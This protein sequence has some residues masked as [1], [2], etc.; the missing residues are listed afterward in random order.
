[1]ICRTGDRDFERDSARR[2]RGRGRGGTAS[3]RRVRWDDTA[4]TRRVTSPSSS[5]DAAASTVVVVAAAVGLVAASRF[6]SALRADS[7][8]G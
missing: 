3:G 5:S 8:Y 1:M 4:V 2:G 6:D 7:I